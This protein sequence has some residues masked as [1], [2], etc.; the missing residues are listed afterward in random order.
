MG[1]GA[2]WRVEL[3]APRQAE[4]FWISAQELARHLEFSRATLK[5]NAPA[6]KAP[7]LVPVQGLQLPHGDGW[8]T[9]HRLVGLGVLVHLS[10]T[11]ARALAARTGLGSAGRKADGAQCPARTVMIETART[12]SSAGCWGRV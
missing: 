10:T 12:G 6:R 3:I 8:S 4:G 1:R 5:L 9:T 2:R 11:S 7:M